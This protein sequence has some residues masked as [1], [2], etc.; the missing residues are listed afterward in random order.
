MTASELDR[1]AAAIEAADEVVLACHVNPDGDALGSLLAMHHLCRANGKRS[2]ASWPEPFEVAPHYEFMPGLDLATPPGDL[3]DHPTVMVIFDCGSL[4]RLGELAVTAKAADSLVVV[5]HHASNDRFGTVNLVDPDA[6]ASAVLVHRLARRLGWEL[7]REAALCLYVGLVTDTGRFQH[8]NTTPEVFHLAE[9]LAAYDLPVS[10]L[11]RELFEKHRFAYLQ[12]V[13]EA[14]GRAELDPEHS[15][16]YTTISQDDLDRHGV[17][18][19]EAE[20]LIDLVRRTAE[21]EVSAVLKEA[22]DGVRVSLRS[23]STVDVAEIAQ[24][25]GGGGH[26]F[27]AGFTSD[28]PLDAVVEKIRA[29]L[30]TV[31]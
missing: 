11:A 14:L 7:N 17:R 16:V 1:A 2:L 6:A 24:Q 8:S 27:A 20:G 28:E 25:F 3:P 15:F 18:L 23:I 30:P 19:D 5:D 22:P 21:A 4:Q 10:T 29:V 12:L 13:A 26:R 31:S 9:E